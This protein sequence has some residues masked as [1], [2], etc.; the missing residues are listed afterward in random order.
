MREGGP[1]VPGPVTIIIFSV[2]SA[3]TNTGLKDT[4]H[5]GYLLEDRRWFFKGKFEWWLAL[6]GRDWTW[7]E[8]QNLSVISQCSLADPQ[9]SAKKNSAECFT[10][11][12]WVQPT[13]VSVTCTAFNIR[14]DP[15]TLSNQDRVTMCYI[16][17]YKIFCLYYAVSYPS[18]YTHVHILWTI[19]HYYPYILQNHSH[20]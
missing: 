18:L 1:V 13:L 3:P 7:N 19:I 5:Y 10:V 12:W 20:Y 17:S 15:Y 2:G 16:Y 9:Y 14:M 4:V 11:N 8:K 6:L